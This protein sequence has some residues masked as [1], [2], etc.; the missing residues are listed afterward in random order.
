ML[1]QCAFL[2]SSD[3]QN[4]ISRFLVQGIGLEFHPL[5]SP[6]FKSMANHKMLCLGIDGRA[7]PGGGDSGGSDLDSAI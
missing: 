4:R 7:L 1:S 2:L 6:V 5:A 3:A